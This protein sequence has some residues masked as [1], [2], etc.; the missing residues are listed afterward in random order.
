VVERGHLLVPQAPGW[1]TE[2]N[3]E[4]IRARPAKQR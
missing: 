1:G 4:A 2:I 3:E